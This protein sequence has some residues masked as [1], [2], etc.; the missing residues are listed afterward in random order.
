MLGIGSAWPDDLNSSKQSCAYDASL[1]TV[2]GNLDG[3]FVAQ[4]RDEISLQALIKSFLHQ[5]PGMTHATAD[6]D[7]AN[8]NHF[9]NMRQALCQLVPGHDVSRQ[10]M[11]IASFCQCCNFVGIGFLAA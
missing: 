2:T 5:T 4:Y 8:I 3:D 7:L 10:C 11:F 6:D 1:V 9:K